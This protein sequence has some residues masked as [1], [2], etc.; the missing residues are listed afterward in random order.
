MSSVPEHPLGSTSTTP[1]PRWKRVIIGVAFSVL[2]AV[3]AVAGAALAQR[4][5]GASVRPFA[6]GTVEIGI[7]P[8]VPGGLDIY[9]PIVDWGV[10][11]RPYRMP[12]LISL[13]FR[14]LDRDA[15]L[16]ALRSG[17][18]ARERLIAV[19]QDLEALVR[20][21]LRRAALFALLGGGVAGILTG[22]MLAAHRGKHWL[23]LG[24]LGGIVTSL[25]A[26]ATF[27]A[28]LARADYG[29][30]I[31]RPSFYARGDELPELLAFSS[32][33]FTVSA[34]YTEDFDR[35]VAGLS[36]M[37]AAA[38]GGTGLPESAL[39]IVLASDIHSNTFVFP[40][41]RR[42]TQGHP[43][44]LA[45]DFALLGTELEEAVVPGVAALSDTV[46]AVSGNHDSRSL[47]RSLAS[48]GVTVL[49]RDGQLRPDG[50]TTGKPVVEVAGLKVAGFEDPLERNESGI[51]GHL[52]EGPDVFLKTQGHNL[53]TWFHNLPV[54]P[55]IVMLHQY[56]LA[57]VLLEDLD[58]NDDGPRVVILAGHDHWAHFQQ[59]GEHLL[60]DG[61]TL[62]AGGPFAIG[63]TP[64]GFALLH[65][66][67][68]HRPRAL[69]L[70]EVEPLSG[71]G[72][73]QRVVL[74]NKEPAEDE[75][76]P[77]EESSDGPAEE[78][79]PEP[80]Q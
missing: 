22:V 39:T 62:G 49:T 34:R 27:A 51:G 56:P 11:F 67:G 60:L 65:F 43:V 80:P 18:G 52:L 9:I 8:A 38:G 16:Q 61:G 73:V 40:T 2:V 47:M 12:L 76:S 31:R 33:L 21:E 71:Q 59:A 36:N 74:S 28:G 45:G 58:A 26:V 19:R 57:Q 24:P 42:Y 14:S 4:A 77:A 29:E 6:L 23:L 25:I 1:R 72:K 69:D 54:R 66:D 37:V 20:A 78:P 15:A 13:R 70:I 64:A 35:A 44:F 55:D 75:T 79:G 53:V 48:A 17:Q 5:A 30:A 68:E 7:W 41:I 32:Q 3:L 10:R 63:E 46:V 50:S